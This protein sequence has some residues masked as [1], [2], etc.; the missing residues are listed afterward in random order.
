MAYAQE[1]LKDFDIGFMFYT[2]AFQNI[3]VKHRHLHPHTHTKTG[4]RGFLPGKILKSEIA[5]GEF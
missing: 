3:S 5:V 4:V 1:F 2:A